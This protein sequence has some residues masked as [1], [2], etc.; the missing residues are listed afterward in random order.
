[1]SELKLDAQPRELKGRKVRQLRRQGLVPVTV[2][3]QDQEPL[4]L[5]VSARSL[6]YLLHQ[7]AGS[8]LVELDVEGDEVKNVL[9]RDI[10][11]DP[12]RHTLMH[13][14]FYAVNMMQKQIVTVP[15]HGVG[16]PEALAAGLMMLQA[17]DQVEIE[18]LPSDIPA[19]IEVDVT[20]LT[21]EESISVAD[22]PAMNGVEYTTDAEET[23]FTMVTSRVEEE[24]EEELLEGDE[25]MEPEVIGASDEE[26]EVVED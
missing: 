18:A 12:V 7:G 8:Q 5:Q 2:Y 11:R 3:G 17:L 10:Q 19:V 21:L 16:E 1:M 23:V 15:I 9:V 4:S 6:D 22:L 24:E 20:G 13:A 26:E 14:D 25:M